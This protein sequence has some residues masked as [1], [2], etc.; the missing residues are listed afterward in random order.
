MEDAVGL[1]VG[2]G[3]GDGVLVGA[4]VADGSADGVAVGVDVAVGTAL[5]V[6]LGTEVAVGLCVAVGAKV[7]VALGAVVGA[8]VAVAFG[9][10]VATE[11]TV[12]SFRTVAAGSGVPPGAPVQAESNAIRTTTSVAANLFATILEFPA[13]LAIQDSSQFDR[14]SIGLPSLAVKARAT[15]GAGIRRTA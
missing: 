13:V 9:A 14:E 15:H 11:G 7:A 12:G 4:G 10:V 8:D 5:G 3:W 2:V 6:V 1:A